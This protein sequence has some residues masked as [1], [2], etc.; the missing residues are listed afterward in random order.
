MKRWLL[1]AAFVLLAVIVIGS[2]LQSPPEIRAAAAQ[3]G[4]IAQ[5]LDERGVTRL[6]ETH[7]LS[8]PFTGRIQKIELKPGDAVQQGQ[9]VAQVSPSDLQRAL[10]LAETEVQRLQAAVIEAED[11]Q[12]E[13]QTK[14]QTKLYIDSLADSAAAAESRRE[15]AVKQNDYAQ[16]AFE[17]IRKLFEGQSAPLE[18]YEQSELRWRERTAELRQRE[19]DHQS[20][21]AQLEAARLLPEMLDRYMHRRQLSA[22][23]LK[24]ELAA[25][26]LQKQEAVRN[27]QQGRLHSPIDG[28][29]LQTHLRNEQFAAAGSPLLTLGNLQELQAEADFL[30]HDAALVQV[31]DAAQIYGAAVGEAE[32]SIPARVVRVEPQAFTKISSLGVEQQRVKIVVAPLETADRLDQRGVGAG[33]RVRVRIVVEQKTDAVV[34]PQTALFRDAENGWSV[35]A[36]RD[37]RAVLQGVEVG[38]QNDQQAE[39]L[40]GL[41]AGEA[42]AI[43]PG[44]DL[45]DGMRARALLA[46]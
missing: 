43:A 33:Y 32:Q 8:M 28:V 7:R 41:Q 16:K 24:Q 36:L 17:R 29:V 30:S 35:F 19:L 25:A 46:P 6:A 45:T 31:G 11:R 9:L 14:Q 40:T 2:L 44:N 3:R 1:L 23:V 42:V 27:Q 18:Q 34:I 22:A 21:Q 26:K 37:G 13:E 39:I 12:V 5:F 38:L 4:R 15:M 20:A 10:D